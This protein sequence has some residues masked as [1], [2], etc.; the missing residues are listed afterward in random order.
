[1]AL[2]HEL[3]G[4]GVQVLILNLS[5]VA[6]HDLTII[7]GGHVEVDGER[8]DNRWSVWWRR[9]GAVPDHPRMSELESRLRREEIEELVLGGLLAACPRWIDDPHQMAHAEHKL[10]QLATA[11]QLNVPVPR[12]IATN[13][14]AA[15]RALATGGVVAKAA[16]AGTGLAPFADRFDAADLDLLPVAPTLLQRRID[17][18]ADLRVAVVADD[19]WIW[20][21]ERATDDVL[22]WRAA[23]PAGEQFAPYTDTSVA[24]AAA[25]ITARLGLS[26]SV[27]D[28]LVGRDGERWFL[29]ANPA[30]QWLFLDGA[31][32]L[33]TPALADH[34]ARGRSR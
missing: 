31:D 17:A 4:R 34:L 6:D 19:C 30:G 21:R 12:T 9:V 16:S 3:T 11:D 1:M 24:Q 13:R 5:T 32:Q 10:V 14:P 26:V 25:Q 20:R 27:Q 22:D 2:Q 15:A 23:D 28:W 33:V 7:P 8:I 18:I 29:E